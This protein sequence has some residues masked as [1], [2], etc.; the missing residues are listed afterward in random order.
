MGKYGMKVR[1]YL[2]F[3]VSRVKMGKV[4]GLHSVVVPVLSQ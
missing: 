1:V 4:K 2:T 3:P